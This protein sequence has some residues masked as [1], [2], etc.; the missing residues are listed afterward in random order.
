[1]TRHIVS[2]LK[3]K[4]N[5]KMLTLKRTI[6]LPDML[7]NNNN[8]ANNNNQNKEEDEVCAWGRGFEFYRIKLGFF[9]G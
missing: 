1:M 7:M 8:V 2:L 3:S 6:S 4:A 5:K 9:Y